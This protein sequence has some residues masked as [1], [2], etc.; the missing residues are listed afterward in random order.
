MKS[1]KWMEGYDAHGPG[2]F[3]AC[4]LF[5]IVHILHHTYVYKTKC[6]SVFFGKDFECQ[7]KKEV[8]NGLAKMYI[9]HSNVVPSGVPQLVMST[10]AK[11]RAQ[12]GGGT[13]MKWHI[14]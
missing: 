12:N 5:I 3:S 6:K 10:F 14:L 2:L 11:N 8:L 4:W 1:D 7:Q 13:G 9:K